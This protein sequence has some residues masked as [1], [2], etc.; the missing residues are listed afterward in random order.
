MNDFIFIVLLFNYL[1]WLTFRHACF[2]VSSVPYSFNHLPIVS[3]SPI[4]IWKINT[5]YQDTELSNRQKWSV[6]KQKKH[7]L[8]IILDFSAF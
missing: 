8:K 3:Q 5:I 4:D 6:G 1:A 2:K 7:I